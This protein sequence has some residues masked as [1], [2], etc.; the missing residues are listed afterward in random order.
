MATK[1]DIKKFIEARMQE[2]KAR[3]N[4]DRDSEIDMAHQQFIAGINDKIKT[5]RAELVAALENFERLVSVADATGSAYQSIYY[6]NP[7]R[8]IETSLF[9]IKDDEI[10]K[11][12][13]IPTV[14]QI[15]NRYADLCDEALQE[16][17]RLIAVTKNMSAKDGIKLL[18]DLGFD[19]SELETVKE[20]TALTIDIDAQKLFIAKEDE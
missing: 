6:E 10:I 17:N 19:T 9:K 7:K 18:K 13:R 2:A 4:T 11:Y 12:F 1:H 16:Y 3:L 15:R 8:S 14:E 5:V 20:I